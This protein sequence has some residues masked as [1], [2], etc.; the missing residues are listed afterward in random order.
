MATSRTTVDITAAPRAV[1]SFASGLVTLV[2]PPR[3]SAKDNAWSAVCADRERAAARAELE[4]VLRDRV[5]STGRLAG[6]SR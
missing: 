1:I 2:M 6:A 5:A 4:L 3:P